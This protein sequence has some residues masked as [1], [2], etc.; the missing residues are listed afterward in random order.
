MSSLTIQLRNI[1]KSFGNGANRTPVL[2][3]VDFH[4]QGGECVFLVGPSGSGKTTMLSILGCILT[5]DAGSVHLLGRDISGLDLTARTVLRRNHIGFIFQRFHLIRGLN[6]LENV[7]VPLTLREIPKADARR[8]AMRLLEAVGLAEKAKAYP[9]QMSVGQNQRVA[10][11]RA[12]VTDPDII[13]AD[14]PTASL[15]EENGA[16]ALQLL[17]SLT[18][19]EGKTVVV[20]THDPRIYPLA[21]RICQL[22]DG[23]LRLESNHEQ[24]PVL[25]PI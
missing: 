7:C 10:I 2:R 8:R 6:T 16:A 14:E 5:A 1:Q 25:Q 11:A 17:K 23:R 21:D 18:L 22:D 15:D 20:V 3:G 4:A 12:L 19:G 13:L 9:N 24:E